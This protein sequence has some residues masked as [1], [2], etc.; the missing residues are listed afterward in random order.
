MSLPTSVSDADPEPSELDVEIH[1]HHMFVISTQLEWW[2]LWTTFVALLAML[3]ALRHQD[4]SL[5]LGIAVI[6]VVLIPAKWIVQ[7]RGRK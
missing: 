4:Q 2:H 3:Y 6:T 5:L 1:H 7:W